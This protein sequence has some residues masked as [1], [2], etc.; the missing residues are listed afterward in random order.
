MN[1]RADADL[2]FLPLPVLADVPRNRIL[3]ESDG[4]FVEVGRRDALPHDVSLVVSALADTWSDDVATAQQ[5]LWSNF[6]ALLRS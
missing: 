3:L 1:V 5:T 6:S 4:P 2:L